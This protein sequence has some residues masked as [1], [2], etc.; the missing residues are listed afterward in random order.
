MFRTSESASWDPE[1]SK[2]CYQY[3][4]ISIFKLNLLENSSFELS[5]E[6][7]TWQFFICRRRS[8]DFF[9]LDWN[10]DRLKIWTSAIIIVNFPIF[11]FIIDLSYRL[12]T[13][14]NVSI[15]NFLFSKMDFFYEIICCMFNQSLLLRPFWRK[16][17]RIDCGACVHL[18]IKLTCLTQPITNSCTLI[19]I[20]ALG[21]LHLVSSMNK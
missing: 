15:E 20:L 16:I 11:E 1:D 21:T 10:L 12:N 9:S 13:S 5:H 19:P 17:S 18:T 6:S 3:R 8:F 14:I 7:L 2:K 4:L